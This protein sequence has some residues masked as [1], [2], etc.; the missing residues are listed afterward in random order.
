MIGNFM[1]LLTKK[2]P[3]FPKGYTW[4]NTK[5]PLSLSKLK[6]HVVVL[7][8]W[9]YCC[10]NCMHV[11]PV[12]SKIQE[13]YQG[14]PVIVIGVHSAKFKNEENPD[15][16]EHAIERYAVKHPVVVDKKHHIW[17]SYFVSA[18]PTTIIIGPNGKVAYKLAGEYSYNQ[19]VQLIDDVLSNSS[20]AGTL[21]KSRIKIEQKS[22]QQHRHGTLS[23]PGK[24]SFSR[25]KD[26]F[27]LSDSNNNRI[28]I[29]KASTGKILIQIGSRESGLMDGSFK[30]ARF[31]RP[32]GVLWQDDKIYVADTENHALREI[33]LP[34]KKVKTLAGT[35]QKGKYVEFG[36]K[37]PRSTELSSPWDL[38]CD[39]KTIFIAMAGLHQ[40]WGYDIKTGHVSVFAGNGREDVIDG[41]AAL[42]E[43][44]QP[45]GLWYK[46]GTLYVADSEASAIRS[47]ALKSGYVSTL[48]GGEGLFFFGDK[49]G[50]LFS[51]QLQHPLGVCEQDG[52]TY[53]ADTYNSSIKAID[54]NEK[55]VTI[56]VGNKEKSVCKFD[57]PNCDTL[58][59]YEPSDVKSD[60]KDIY[61]VDTNNHLVRKFET[62]SKL[63]KTLDI[64]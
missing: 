9:T 36:I 39:G 5:E 19:M 57:D 23:F 62:N 54:L 17:G 29:I 52:T 13:H 7:D 14:K 15:N 1:D 24:M 10:I 25:D 21:A 40:I 47:I 50:S 42:A 56:L 32:Q 43:L 38:A 35:G 3:E 28:L 12:L 48:A 46:S 27:A 53:V 59:L 44:A 31:W 16:I 30:E 6:G 60:G 4:F 41:P 11:L 22:I 55:N 58:G 26:K 51:A 49:D 20:Q 61:I 8:F 37:Y 18:W 2:A 64:K 63:L 34:S 33:D 45:S